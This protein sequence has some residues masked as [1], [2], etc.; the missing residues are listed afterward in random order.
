M[1]RMARRARNPVEVEV[2]YHPHSEHAGRRARLSYDPVTDQE[3]QE[4]V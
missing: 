1:M 4:W 2:E 3:S